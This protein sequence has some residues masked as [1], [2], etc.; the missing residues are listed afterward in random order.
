MRSKPTTLSGKAPG[1][2]KLPPALLMWGGGAS[3]SGSGSRLGL[4]G[5]RRD[6]AA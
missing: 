1:G 4:L 6:R 5:A 3:T 2:L